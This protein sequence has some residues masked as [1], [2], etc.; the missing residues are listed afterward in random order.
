M[1]EQS[2]RS[3]AIFTIHLHHIKPPPDDAESDSKN[4][5][6]MVIQ[7]KFHFVDLAG[8]ERAKK[9]GA[10]GTRL[11]E[12]ISING[13]LLALGNVIAALGDARLKSK[14]VP[15][16]DSKITRLLQD[17]LGG[18]S[19]T[20]MIACVSPARSNMLETKNT[21]N[22]ANRAKN[23]KNKAVVN[24][25]PRS[26]QILQLRQRVKELERQL[27]VGGSGMK[28]THTYSNDVLQQQIEQINQLQND[29]ND[30]N[31]E[32]I[33]LQEKI[34]NLR[35]N[36]SELQD[37]Y[38]SDVSVANSDLKIEKM[39]RMNLINKIKETYGDNIDLNIFSNGEFNENE[40][41]EIKEQVIIMEKLKLE[42]DRLKLD[43]QKLNKTIIS[44]ESRE[45]HIV[46]NLHQ[47]MA[48]LIKGDFTIDNNI[49]LLPELSIIG[50]ERE[51]TNV[52]LLESDD[53]C[54]EEE[55][56]DDEFEDSDDDDDDDD[57][58]GSD[59][60]DISMSDPKKKENKKKLKETNCEKD[61]LKQE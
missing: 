44:N 1:N 14:H 30:S 60:N 43:N 3:H 28:S 21:L 59:D 31:E 55:L 22:Y 37:K 20:L 11:A 50:E 15:F 24:R 29:L 19:M 18:N 25:D 34:K 51:S 46:H 47:S 23:I 12:G 26:R 27:N 58:N 17:S 7:S 39:K 56:E 61:K 41:K 4:S 6:P 48:K 54:E 33:K 52:I 32:V 36:L 10:T 45:H 38:Y 35:L 9:T 13:G 16:R 5:E 2:S 40:E 49:N 8:S 53:D 57:I 42:N